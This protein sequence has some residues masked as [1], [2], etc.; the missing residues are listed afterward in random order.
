[1]GIL[2]KDAILAAADLKTE[3]VMVPEWGGE[4]IIRAM[5]GSE[6]DAFEV[7]LFVGEGENRKFQGE[8][9]RA[10]LLVQCI[11]DEKGERIF[12]DADVVA[13]G[14]RNAAV[15]DRLYDIASRLSGIGKKDLDA[16]VKN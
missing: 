9:V 14:A 3:T 5:R 15:L 10:K 12:S 16:A 6:R 1:M 7:A 4:V 11:V 8:H 2:T 13:L